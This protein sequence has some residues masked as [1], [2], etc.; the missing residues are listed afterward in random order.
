[1]RHYRVRTR[2]CLSMTATPANLATADE[3]V[4]SVGGVQAC[5]AHGPLGFYGG[6]PGTE[7]GPTKF[8]ACPR[9]RTPRSSLASSVRMTRTPF[10]SSTHGH[11]VRT[12][13]A[14][15]LAPRG[16]GRQRTCRNPEHGQ[17]VRLA[18]GVCARVCSCGALRA[19]TYVCTRLCAAR[20]VHPTNC[21]PAGRVPTEY[22]NI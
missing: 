11:T 7:P 1:M 18:A 12:E 5:F 4:E 6:W 9:T 13:E 16:R 3:H 8:L 22:N 20:H 2:A 14:M 19:R 21:P 15:G 17:L 10:F